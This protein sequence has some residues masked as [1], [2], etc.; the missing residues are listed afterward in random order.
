M[1]KIDEMLDLDESLSKYK[2]AAM[3][4]GVNY[5]LIPVNV[6][7]MGNDGMK[8]FNKI[9]EKIKSFDRITRTKSGGISIADLHIPSFDVRTSKTCVEMTLLTTRCYR[10][11]FRTALDDPMKAEAQGIS[12]RQ[13][14]NRFKEILKKYDIDLEEYAI[15]NGEEIKKQIPSPKIKLAN[16][17][18]ADVILDNVHHIDFHSS[19]PAGLANSHPEFRE[20]LEDLYDQRKHDPV[21]KAIF[22]YSIGFM[23]SM[24]GCKARYAILSRDAIMD[25]NKRVDQLALELTFANRFVLCY[26]TDGI[27]YKGEIYHGEG[28]GS[29]LGQWHNDHINCT[30]RAR[31]AGVYEYIEDGKYT[32][33]VRGRTKLDMKKPRSDWKW[34][35][36]YNF[37]CEAVM[38]YFDELRGITTNG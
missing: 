23:Q 37:E 21:I 4:Y 11:Q 2:S 3:T 16:D 34:G 33:V 24:S 22:N 25:N 5:Y 38:Y 7:A 13:A 6:I 31:S 20:C 14:F 9:Y 29:G 17:Y 18:V 35:D 1:M 30:W 10:F 12:G 8:A 27:W 26:N 28:E 15:E 32:P 19:Y 36:I